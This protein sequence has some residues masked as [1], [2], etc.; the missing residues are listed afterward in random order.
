MS[1]SSIYRSAA[2]GEAIRR[3][4]LDR[5]AAWHVPHTCEV[6]T[7]AGAE[8]RVVLAGDGGPTVV[9]VPGT[10][11]NAAT[12]L[13]LATALAARYRTVVVDVP[14]QPGLSS[15][16]R[17]RGGGRLGWY[18]TWLSEVIE[19]CT[20][21]PVIVLGHS[22][23][24]AIALS[25]TSP[26]VE[27]QVLV[28]PGGLTSLRLTPRLLCASAA[29]LAL[30][31][32]RHSA[33][34]LRTMSAPDAPAPRPALVEWMTLVARHARSSGAPEPARAPHQTLPRR[35]ATGDQDV[36]LPP[37]R[38]AAPVRRTLSVELRVLPRAGHLVI[39]EHPDRV[40]DL[41]AELV[42]R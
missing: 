11:F 38:L 35:V 26:R 2:G 41:V 3:W 13:P 17:G 14:G 21:G 1:G 40:A 6:F 7:A 29:W 18:G 9:V 32:P 30:P 5:L 28:S 36:F 24:A 42:G 31:R 39:E 15:P 8:T 33:W 27:G 10:N 20:S 16:E 34:L 25:T 12:C 4:C 22:F 19:A 37:R 23:G